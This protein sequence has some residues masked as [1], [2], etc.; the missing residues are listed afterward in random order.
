[1]FLFM[2]DKSICLHHQSQ[3]HSFILWNPLASVNGLESDYPS[4]FFVS[5][6]CSQ[7]ILYLSR[8]SPAECL[9]PC[10]L[11]HDSII[12]SSQASLTSL[13]WVMITMILS[14]FICC[15]V[16]ISSRMPSLS[17]ALV[18][19]SRQSTS[20]PFSR[21]RM[22]A[23]RC[24]WPPL[25]LLLWPLTCVPYPCSWDATKSSSGYPPSSS[26]GLPSSSRP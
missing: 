13:S 21:A 5:S 25:R 20:V 1:M 11:F 16:S 6:G 4:P 9:L 22:M 8:G 7:S 14:S 26:S 2:L 23:M 17:R 10:P 15:R 3:G 19:S 18:G 12:T 24:F